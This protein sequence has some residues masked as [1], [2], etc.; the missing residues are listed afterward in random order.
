MRLDYECREIELVEGGILYRFLKDGT[1]EVVV[2]SAIKAS[3][4][5]KV[6]SVSNELLE[7]SKLGERLK[8]A[9]LYFKIVEILQKRADSK[10]KANKE[11]DTEDILN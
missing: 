6:L 11:A 9:E 2:R 7:L 10:P 5:D 3:L 1:N 8:E 4:E